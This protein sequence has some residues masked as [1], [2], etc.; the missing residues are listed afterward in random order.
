MIKQ[1]RIAKIDKNAILPTRK[2]QDDAGLDLFANEFTRIEGCEVGIVGT[3]IAADIPK[4]FVGLI[5]SKSRSDFCLA[6]A[7]SMLGTR[8]KSGSK[9]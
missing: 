5:L 2:H 1:I 9:L 6:A 3:G 8:A 7:L 4:G